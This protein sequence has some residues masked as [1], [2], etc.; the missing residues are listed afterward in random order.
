MIYP[1]TSNNCWDVSSTATETRNGGGDSDAII[2]MVN[3]TIT[4]YQAN[5][6][7]VYA[8]GISSGAM[9]TELLL[10][11]YPDV[12]KAGSEFSGVPAGCSNVFDEYCGNGSEMT[13]AWWGNKVRAMYPGYTGYRPRIQLWHGTADATINYQ[14]QIAAVDEWTNVFGLSATPNTSVAATISTYSFTH[15][16]WQNTCGYTVIDE[17]SEQNGPHM[18]DV[19]TDATYVI[20]FLG[21][22]QAGATDPEVAKCGTQ[23]AGG[24]TDSGSDSAIDAVA[25]TGADVG[26]DSHADSAADSGAD[27]HA[28]TAVE[29]AVDS[30]IDTN[31]ADTNRPPDTAT[32]ATATDTGTGTDAVV[33][34]DTS[35]SGDS[36][37]TT[38]SGAPTAN[39]TNGCSCNVIGR[40]PGG[41]LSALFGVAIALVA[42]RRRTRRTAQPS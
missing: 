41:N 23:D 15:A 36:A 22:D 24:G 13:A 1:Q 10:A 12:F 37:T 21:L 19:P 2:E 9:M 18:T 20:P 6:N 29:A 3:Y 33:A 40:S 8:T 39:A 42:I 14:N 30:A 4:K 32:T 35:R 31:I 7:R 17:W 5:A 34:A 11:L 26:V 16:T 25:D 27:V 28:D 38:D